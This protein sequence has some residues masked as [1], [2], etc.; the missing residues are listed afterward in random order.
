MKRWQAAALPEQ[1]QE[2]IRLFR[3][4]LASPEAQEAMTSFLEKRKPDFT[5]FD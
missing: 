5:R 1:M 4:R 3:E 2:E